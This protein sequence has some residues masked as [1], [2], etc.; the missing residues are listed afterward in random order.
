MWPPKDAD[1]KLRHKTCVKTD[2]I[3][4][5]YHLL[6]HHL[7]PNAWFF[8]LPCLLVDWQ[9][10]RPIT[11]SCCSTPDSTLLVSC[12]PHQD[13][14]SS[15]DYRVCFW[16]TRSRIVVSWLFLPSDPSLFFF[17]WL[18]F[19]PDDFGYLCSV[20]SPVSVQPCESSQAHCAAACVLPTCLCTHL[21][22][23]FDSWIFLPLTLTVPLLCLFIDPL[24]PTF[25]FFFWHRVF[26]EPCL[27]FCQGFLNFLVFDYFS[28][29]ACAWTQMPFCDLNCY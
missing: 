7:S 10:R 28:S 21:C 1:P 6:Y 5:N 19:L 17:F 25:F 20:A 24:C 15:P 29:V 22:L 26:A 27:Y 8:P 18:W 11:S 13:W 2:Y 12:K 9:V 4:I 23:F 16:E 3:S 14:Q